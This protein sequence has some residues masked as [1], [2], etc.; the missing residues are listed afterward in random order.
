[1]KSFIF[2]IIAILS[3]ASCVTIPAV[4]IVPEYVGVDPK[5]QPLVEEYRWWAKT[6]G[7]SFTKQ[8]TMGFTHIKREN[9]I[10]ICTFGPNWREIDIDIDFFSSHTENTYALV[11]HEL[12]HCYCGRG[13]DYGPGIEYPTG[14]SEK[15]Q[16]ALDWLNSGGERPGYWDDTCPTSIMYPIVLDSQCFT[17]HFRQYMDEMF[18]RCEPY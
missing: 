3:C 13:H 1:M 17:S 16:V 14:I 7:I 15:I 6:H 11:F 5:L 18:N 8:V 2:G 10:G 12:N 9:V 4:K